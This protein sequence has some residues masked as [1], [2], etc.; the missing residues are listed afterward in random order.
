MFFSNRTLREAWKLARARCECQRDGH[1]HQDRCGEP[2]SWEYCELIAP[3]G[4]QAG[5]WRPLN[6]GGQDSADNC[7]I[8][9]WKCAAASLAE[10]SAAS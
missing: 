10:P 9:C 2:L 1:G 3:G 8:I 4:W 6:E 5:L 7:E